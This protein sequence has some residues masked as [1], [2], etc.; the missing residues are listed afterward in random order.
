[1]PSCSHCQHSLNSHDRTC[2]A[3]GGGIPES[4]R[5]TTAF[6]PGRRFPRWKKVVFGIALVFVCL[7]TCLAP[8]VWRAREMARLTSC[9]CNMKQ[10][11]LALHAYADMHGTFP[12][13]YIADE[14]GRPMHSW[15]VLLALNLDSA[16]VYK[17]YD[18]SEPW[19]SPKNLKLLAR[20]PSTYLCPS[21]R[22]AAP[23]KG[24]VLA[25]LGLLACGMKREHCQ[26][27]TSYV[28]VF[29]KD[30]M[31]RGAEPV[32]AGEVRDGFSSTLMIVE[33]TASIPWTKP[34]DLDVARHPKLGDPQGL[35]SA[36]GHGVNVALVDGSCRVLK[37]DTPQAIV[38]ALY[39][40]NGGEPVPDG[41]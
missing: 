38:D 5:P 39:T 21:A 25:A 26:T 14:H 22:C 28:A 13:A 8:A 6:I 2:P 4:V 33:T 16:G 19:D 11:A 34:E 18:F 10:I 40:R 36:H 3:C 17:D 35:N 31:F 32:K 7:S 29:G 27:H 1:M 20:V 9:S 12:P 15:R 37:F 30:C 24:G 23:P 41:F